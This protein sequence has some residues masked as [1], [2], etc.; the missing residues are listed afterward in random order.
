MGIFFSLSFL[1]KTCVSD[2]SIMKNSMMRIAGFGSFCSC[3]QLNNDTFILANSCTGHQISNPLGDVWRLCR[4]LRCEEIQ[5]EGEHLGNLHLKSAKDRN[6][7]N[8]NHIYIYSIQVY[9]Y[10]TYL[11]QFVSSCI[12]LLIPKSKISKNHTSCSC[13]LKFCKCI[14]P[15]EVKS[16][17]FCKRCQHLRICF[18]SRT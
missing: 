12:Q 14:W 16:G 13:S 18:H 11:Y 9:M 6:Q 7:R 3:T 15:F 17:D 5:I 1:A 10:T 2:K 8:R 4:A